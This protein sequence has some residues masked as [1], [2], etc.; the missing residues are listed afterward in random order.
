MQHL[1]SAH[2]LTS[3]FRKPRIA[4]SVQA[5]DAERSQP[6]F[7]RDVGILCLLALCASAALGQSVNCEPVHVATGTVLTFHLQTRLQADGSNQ[8][9]LLPKG[10]AI[11]VKVS[12][13][14]DSTVDHD[15]T[16]FG[17]RIVSPVVLGNQVIIHAESEVRGLLVLLRSKA[18]PEGFRYELL[19]TS[20]RDNGKSY[21][22]TASQHD[23]F[24]DVS[25]QSA[26]PQEGEK[27]KSPSESA[28]LVRN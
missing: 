13:S 22:L 5:V 11:F 26:S 3:L 19:L 14:I 6:M 4:E 10:T 23:S 2:E 16:E 24:T 1:D 17:G 15:G 21:D 28:P 27:T 9:D 20:V 7:R 25:S 8:I 12:D 18:H